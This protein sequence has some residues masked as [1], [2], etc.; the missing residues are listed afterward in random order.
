MSIFN[1]VRNMSSKGLV[2]TA[3]TIGVMG[4]AG[5]KVAGA[6]NISIGGPS[7]CDGNAV[8]YCGA[9][10]TNDL[11]SKYNNSG[12]VR[13]IYEYFG[14]GP[15]EVR[16]MDS[17]GVKVVAGKVTK[18]GDVLD[19]NGKVIATN[20]LTAGR[21]NISGSTHVT[22]R[23]TSFYTRPPSVSFLSNSLDAFVVLK[24]NGEFKYAILA[25]CGNPV[26]AT[27]KAPP[28]P[29][30]HPAYEVEKKVRVKG[31]GSEYGKN[32]KVKPGTHVS[33]TV[34]V[35][36]T[37][38]AAAQNV[39]VKDN[40][41]AHV[42]YVDGTLEKDGAKQG[43]AQT[44]NFFSSGVNVD[45]IAPG[46]TVKF[47]FEAIVGPNENPDT[48][49]DETLTNV[50]KINAPQLPPKDSSANVNKNCTPPKPEFKCES[51]QGIANSRLTYTFKAKASV[52]NGAK[53]TGY[54][55]DFGDGQSKKVA[56]AKHNTSIAHSYADLD[57]EKNYTVKVT[58]H[59][60]VNG[61]NK[62]DS[63]VNCKVPVKVAPK[64]A[65]ECTGL[66]LTVGA[67]RTITAQTSVA[68]KNGAKLVA[69]GYDFD[70]GGTLLT[71]NLN[72][73]SHTYAA[74]G[75]YVVKA[76]VVFNI[77]GKNVNSQCQAPVTFTPPTCEETNGGQPCVP[78]C[79]EENGGQTCETCQEQNNGQPCE[80]TPTCEEMVAEQGK[81]VCEEVPSELVNTGPGETAAMFLAVTVLSTI[82]YRT[83][84]S[85]RLGQ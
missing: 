24:D 20:A 31:D 83:L 72:P 84:L 67:N 60:K 85:R 74:D 17:N 42:K 25:A 10:S 78:T 19:N 15:N 70:D 47:S 77:D 6:Q 9:H 73:V 29:E 57:Q 55:F 35:K 44:Q 76:N 27:P 34:N 2:L 18:S 52:S 50:A 64:P 32:V 21:E 11:I 48:C 66:K 59:F 68:T 71:N 75:D 8:M 38:D 40:L 51:L 1:K 28:T 16:S 30:K 5:L 33:Y 23:G 54:T 82:G 4:F 62:T 79:E 12:S 7:D 61:D 45:R 56:S 22:N 53:V 49:K 81:G 3:L 63:G 65:A 39:N 14:I 69:I 43:P 58:V 80:E 13:D 41:P 37:G 36:S 46:T 26:K